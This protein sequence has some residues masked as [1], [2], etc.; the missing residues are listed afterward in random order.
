MAGEGFDFI[1]SDSFDTRLTSRCQRAGWDNHLDDII[2]WLRRIATTPLLPA[3]VSLIG[4]STFLPEME[5]WFPCE[6]VHAQKIDRLC[7]EF[8]WTAR[9]AM[10]W[11]NAS[12]M[13]C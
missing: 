3:N 4:L 8:F 5:F 9:H 11:V 1:E 13:V 6:R 12:C 2:V 7:Q 10:P